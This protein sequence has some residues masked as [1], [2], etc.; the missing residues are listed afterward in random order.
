MSSLL[1][2]ECIVFTQFQ[3]YLVGLFPVPV[4]HGLIYP[5]ILQQLSHQ[6]FLS[7]LGS[8]IIA[9]LNYVHHQ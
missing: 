7:V 9:N 6:A 2:L 1:I 4:N 8:Q 3:L 5:I